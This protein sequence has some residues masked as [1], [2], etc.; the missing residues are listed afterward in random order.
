MLL[1]V[2]AV[3]AGASC[4]PPA[5]SSPP[6]HGYLFQKGPYQALYGANGRIVRL[7]HDEDGDGKADSVTI[8]GA[9]GKPERVEIDTDKD[10][11]VDRWEYLGPKG[12]EKVGS[13]RRKPGVP[14]LWV[15]SDPS[16][17]MTRRELDEDGDGK[18]D[19]VETYAGGRLARV[20]VDSDRDGRLDRW[21]DWSTGRLSAEEFDTNADGVADRRLRYR[22]DG[23]P[24]GVDLLAPG[25]IRGLGPK[26]AATGSGTAPAKAPGSTRSP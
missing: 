14:D 12:L 22:A 21:Q 5:D 20:A 9:N 19:R 3:A 1:L 23:T 11:V 8:F 6:L 4:S 13:S 17:E 16:G 7:L 24:A 15:F 10:G 18:V 26:A 2:A 25:S